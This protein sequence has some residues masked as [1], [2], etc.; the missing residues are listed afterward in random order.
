[1][2]FNQFYVKAEKHKNVLTEILFYV[3]SVIWLFQ[4]I[5][6]NVG[7]TPFSAES[8]ATT[9]NGVVTLNHIGKRF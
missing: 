2:V 8:P 4:L 3:L 1:M 7:M 6:L 5:E 9:K